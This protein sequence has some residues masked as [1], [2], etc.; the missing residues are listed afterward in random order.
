MTERCGFS[1][2]VLLDFADSRL[3][4]EQL[5]V[6]QDHVTLCPSCAHALQQLGPGV[7]RFG[8]IEMDPAF[9][10]SMRLGLAARLEGLP[11]PTSGTG[12]ASL[13]L[14]K[15]LGHSPFARLARAL[16]GGE[17]RVPKPIAWAA[18]ACLWMVVTGAPGTPVSLRPALGAPAVTAPATSPTTSMIREGL[19]APYV[20]AQRPVS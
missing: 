12:R 18:A 4:G 11:L 20:M 17:F 10:E 5:R 9:M 19:D 3:E 8:S 2:E 7:P 13:S 15:A 16:F 1:R 14:G 6:V